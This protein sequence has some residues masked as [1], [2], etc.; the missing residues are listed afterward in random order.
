M[1][2]PH[3]PQFIVPTTWVYALHSIFGV[4]TMTTLVD[5]TLSSAQVAAMLGIKPTTL[6]IWRHKGKGPRFVKLG[7]A[8]QAGV[9]Y[10]RSEVQHWMQER[11]FTST[12]AYC[13][14]VG[15]L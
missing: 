12:S 15:A 4:V 13:A 3:S 14:K 11:T 2:P 1:G 10:S 5:E 8:K 9:V 7:P 6:E